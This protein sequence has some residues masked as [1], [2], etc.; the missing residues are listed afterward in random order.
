MAKTTASLS[1]SIFNLTNLVKILYIDMST[2][3]YN[4][5]VNQTLLRVSL[6]MLGVIQ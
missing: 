1:F 6:T 2:K 5:L 4:F 3:Q